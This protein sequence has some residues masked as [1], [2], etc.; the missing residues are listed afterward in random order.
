MFECQ[1]EKNFPLAPLSNFFKAIIMY[2]P[3]LKFEF[4][5]H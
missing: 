2:F 3:T 1:E 5:P 4:P